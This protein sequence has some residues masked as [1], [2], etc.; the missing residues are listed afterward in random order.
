MGTDCSVKAG[1]T[2]THLD[3]W[4][5]FSSVI[6]SGLS[7]TKSNALS[8]IR[9][10]LN[11]RHLIEQTSHCKDNRERYKYWLIQAKKVIKE[12]DSC[13]NITFYHEYDDAY[14]EEVISNYNSREG[15]S[16]E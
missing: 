5:V 12:A 10:L 8:K 11:K 7:M 4:Y 16:N 2:Y 9:K 15:M 3:R 14:F 13:A 1:N 6:V